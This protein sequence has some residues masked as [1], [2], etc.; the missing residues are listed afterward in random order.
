MLTQAYLRLPEPDLANAL[1]ANQKQLD[2]PT[3]DENR[4]AAARL[5]RGEL[6]LRVQ[7]RQEARKALSRIA[8]NAPLAILSRARRL[9][10]RSYQDGDAW[11]EAAAGDQVRVSVMAIT[12]R[13]R[14]MPSPDG[15]SGRMPSVSRGGN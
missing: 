1:L 10:A 4:L 5:L 9:Q 15:G 2:Q 11:A 8:A 7:D 14:G 12:T 6:L 13:E 3:P